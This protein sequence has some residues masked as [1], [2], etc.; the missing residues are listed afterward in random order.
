MANNDQYLDELAKS[1]ANNHVRSTIIPIKGF[2]LLPEAKF[3]LLQPGSI[4]KE[5]HRRVIVVIGNGASI[6]AGLP[7]TEKAVE[8]L[9]DH[10]SVP[11]SKVVIDKEL[12]RLESVQRLDRSQFETQVM[13]MSVTEHSGNLIRE[14]LVDLYKRK[15]MPSLTYEILAHLLKHRFVDAIINFNFDELLD[16]AISDE[17]KPEEYHLILSDGDCPSGDAPFETPL[18]KPFYIKPHGTV[19]HPST[20]RFTREDYFRLPID[21]QRV[22]SKLFST[23]P[24]DLISIGFAMES[25]EFNQIASSNV[26]ENPKSKLFYIKRHKL[27]N[28]LGNKYEGPFLIPVSQKGGLSRIL[29]NLWKQTSN[30]FLTGYGSRDIN[31]HRLLSQLFQDEQKYTED[32]VDYLWDRTVIELCLAI[33]KARGFMTMSGLSSGRPGKYYQEYQKLEDQTISFKALCK[34]LGL[35]DVAYGYDALR[36]NH[37]DLKAKILS[38]REFKNDLDNFLDKVRNQLSSN[39]RKLVFEKQRKKVRSTLI[40]HFQGEEIEVRAAPEVI[41]DNLFQEPTVIRS[42][43]ALK[44]LTRF[45]LTKYPWKYLLV[46][47]ETGKWLKEETVKKMMKETVG[48][49]TRAI[50]LIIADDNHKPELKKLYKSKLWFGEMSWWDQNRHLTLLL[51]KNMKEICSI[52]FTRQRR[53]NNIVPVFLNSS[54]SQIVHEVFK[55]YYMR[56]QGVKIIDSKNIKEFVLPPL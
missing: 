31:R 52:Y 47:A 8:Q 46:V 53:T 20:L 54:D 35:K 23:N 32:N 22:I 3:K 6:D 17:L 33:A 41:Y 25:F 5:Y 15:F 43:T 18:P 50:Y 56:S 34:S 1:L 42:Q 24:V 10:I 19:S 2:D 30:H 16:Q 38:E 11:L 39:S 12:E 4:I 7:T 26:P 13:A 49:N 55:A 37:G 48:D 29:N 9:S 45:L 44:Y 21:I 36:L 40:H 51:N 28:K 27:K 14:K